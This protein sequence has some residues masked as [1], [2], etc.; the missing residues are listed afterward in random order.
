MSFPSTVRT[1]VWPSLNL[2]GPKSLGRGSFS[3]SVSRYLYLTVTLRPS[4]FS[5]THSHRFSFVT[6]SLFVSKFYSR[7]PRWYSV[8][9]PP[10]LRPSSSDISRLRWIWPFP[11]F[12]S[13]V[14]I[15]FMT[16]K[17]GK[18]EFCWREISRERE[19]RKFR[20]RVTNCELWNSTV[21]SIT[22]KIFHVLKCDIERNVS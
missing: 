1:S 19:E 12:D 5:C 11:F 17:R 6:Q 22:T 15:L 20:T 10:R 18:Y 4:R 7:K 8:A 21:N 14:F 3:G 16:V 2:P 13:G 9:C